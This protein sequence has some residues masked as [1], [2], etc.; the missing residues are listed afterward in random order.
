MIQFS[1]KSFFTCFG[2]IFFNMF[3][4]VAFAQSMELVKTE[5]GCDI[6]TDVSTR[7]SLKKI[8]NAEFKITWQWDGECI[9]GLAQGLGNQKMD[10]E[11]GPPNGNSIHMTR[12]YYHAGYPVGYGKFSLKSDMLSLQGW[13]FNHQKTKIFFSGLG[14]TGIDALLNDTMVQ[15]P[16]ENLSDIQKGQMFQTA[17]R[18]ATFEGTHCGLH[19]TRFP[20]CGFDTGEST[21]DVFYI[22]ES[23]KTG[24]NYADYKASSYT[25]CPEPRNPQSCM[26]L[27]Q[28]KTATYRAEIISYIEQAKPEVEATLKR[29]NAVLVAA[30]KQDTSASAK[31]A[32]NAH[33]T[34]TTYAQSKPD[35]SPEFLQSMN[36]RSVGQLF[37]MAD[38][39]QSKGDNATTRIVLRKLIERFPDHALAALAAKQ[40]ANLPSP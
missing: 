18:F 5:G 38:D 14:L 31:S 11:L 35:N 13:A 6:Y 9:G 40:L 2:L 21:Y 36:K 24:D 28:Q 19:K 12:Q 4:F 10:V 34:T 15:L 32:A 33:T 25:F 8:P 7:E 23:P 29:M 37:S 20:E 1:T 26:A 22:R 17:S 30:G 39:F 3:G 27:V 16:Q